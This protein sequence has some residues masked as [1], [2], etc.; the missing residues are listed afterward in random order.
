[1]AE[2]YAQDAIDFVRAHYSKQLDWSD[3]SVQGIE[4]VAGH[5][6]DTLPDPPPSEQQI[7]GFAKMLGSYV[8]EV[9]RRNHGAT[10]GM[11]SMGG[12]KM[13]G[14]KSSHDG[15]TFWP[16]GR[17]LKRLMNGPEDNIWH[18]YQV[19]LSEHAAPAQPPPLPWWK[20]LF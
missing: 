11:V 2:A 8:G 9:F 3:D 5:L 10:W 20:R 7:H 6:H 19:L 17:V 1:M 18:Y 16:W 14:L 15:T 4:A 12:E 13:P